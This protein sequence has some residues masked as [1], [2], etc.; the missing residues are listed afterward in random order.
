MSEAIS[1]SQGTTSRPA[2]D[3]SETIAFVGES[4][5]KEE[6]DIAFV[7]QGLRPVSSANGN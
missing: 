5:S 6:R 1:G 2:H 4:F 3:G 7:S